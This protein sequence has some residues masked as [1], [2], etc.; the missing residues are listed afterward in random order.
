[1]ST[2]R[3]W[4]NTVISRNFLGDFRT[5]ELYFLILPI[6]HFV[7]GCVIYIITKKI[8]IT[9]LIPIVVYLIYFCS[10]IEK[11]YAILFFII[12]PVVFSISGTLITAGIYKTVKSIRK[13]IKDK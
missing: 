6:F 8:F 10:E 5:Y 3:Y 1:M 13:L 11:I 2:S 7:Y 9:N 12:I 4:G